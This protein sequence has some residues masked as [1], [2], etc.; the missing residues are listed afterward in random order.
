VSW[1]RGA[2]ALLAPFAV[3]GMLPM[4]CNGFVAAITGRSVKWKGRVI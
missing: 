4:M 3:Y 1:Y 2:R